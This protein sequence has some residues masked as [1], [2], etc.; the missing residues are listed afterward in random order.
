MT[1]SLLLR[2]PL[3]I[4]FAGITSLSA[5]AGFQPP[6]VSGRSALSEPS[7]SPDGRE[8]LF[9]AGGDIWTVPAEGG[10][11]R[12]LVAHPAT[13]SRPL[14]APDGKSVA[15]ISTRTGNGDIYVLDLASGAL[16]RRTFDDARDG[17][18]AWSRDGKWLYYSSSTGDV[19]G[20]NDVWRVPSTGGQPATVAGDRYA[21]EYWAAPAPDGKAVAITARGTTS[22]QWWRHGHSHIDE[23]EIWMIR[24]VAAATPEYARIGDEGNGKDAWPMWAPDGR[25]VYY[26]SDRG[27]NENLWVR[28]V[29]GAARALTQFT[30]GRV[31]WPSIALDGS[32]IA[33]ERDYGIWRYDVAKGSASEVPVTL[34]GAVAETNA[35]RQTLTQGFGSLAVA[36]D[37]RK[38][39]F[40]ARGE[41]FVVSSRDGGE[42]TRLSETPELEGDPAWLLDS[43]RLVYASHRGGGWH[44][45]LQDVS[46]RA[47]RALTSGVGRDV[48]P[49]V[50]PD[51]R[52]IAYQ[53]SGREVRV[54]GID[55]TGDRKLADAELGDP[56]FVSADVIA[57]SPDSKWLAYVTPDARGFANVWV[58]PVAGGAA[59]QVSFGADANVGDVNWSPDGKFLLY[60]SA[61][62]TETPRIVRVDLVPRTPRFRED[63][64]RDLFGPTPPPV[65]PAVRPAT[66]ATPTSAARDSARSPSADDSAWS[67]RST[68]RNAVTIAFDGIRQRASIVPTQGLGIGAL[69]ISPDSRTLAFTGSAGGQQQIYALALDELAR[70]TGLRAITTSQGFK[71]SLQWSPDSRELWF[72][73]GGRIAAVNVDSRAARSVSASAEIDVNFEAEKRAV[74]RQA[75]TYLA[76]NFFD[77]K[78]NGADWNGLASRVEPYVVGS[79]TPD[80]LRRVLSLMIG[81]LNASHLGISGPT[82]GAV[83]VPVARL[84]VRFDRALLERDGTARVSEVIQQGPAD[85]ARIAVGD[86]IVAVNDVALKSGLSLD[87]LLMGKVGRQVSLTVRGG[88]A[89]RRVVLRPVAQAAE[90]AL[91]Y[92]Q[93]VEDRRAYVAKV[94]G[95]RLGYV[96]MFDMTQPSL[97]QLYLD[98]DAENQGREGVVVDVRNNN[99]GFVNVYAIDVLSR[100]SYLQF[101]SRGSG[102]TPA[103][104]S[105]GQRMLDR[106]TVLVTNQ[107]TL[108]D[109]EDFTEGY[110]SLGLGKVVGEPTAGWII[111]TSNV[112]LLDGSTTLRLPGTRVTDARG[113]DMEMNPRPVDVL[114]IRPIGES[115]SAK[116]TQLDVAVRTLLSTLTKRP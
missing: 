87:S 79:R 12:L 57:W 78:M 59:R 72:L 7:F 70:E 103:R 98:L 65:P 21:S 26:M 85:V 14:Y 105:L 94:S 97:D 64:F 113:Q 8:L 6:A 102:A 83:L 91:V 4:A 67:P 18:D 48:A 61:M 35:E 62:R 100:R 53:R 95:G 58:V 82:S 10:V 13:E 101:T 36:P 80:D 104:S 9:V 52:S 22:G 112:P 89:N 56:P 33:F 2:R 20:M 90:K 45:Y 24:D 41:L 63:Q 107:H 32:A 86:Q 75:H 49:R 76:Q 68:E 28:P 115:Y 43:R 116:D 38:A 1:L 19:S 60:A 40:L 42:A 17:L 27:G 108:S 81:E 99:G 11:A 16:V 37:T 84:G 77:E 39:A 54:V 88:G 109:G 46:T 29:G 5:P 25:S 51:G 74:F 30:N 73:E 93:W 71:N 31:L 110:R 15:F 69:Q 111:F 47:E 44:L 66:P 23:S 55:G 50:S 34:R 114:S 92:R 3:T 96:H 106:P